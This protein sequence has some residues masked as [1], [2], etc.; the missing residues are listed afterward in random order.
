M[1]SFLYIFYD[2]PSPYESMNMYISFCGEPYCW[3]KV[4]ANPV[5]KWLA[6]PSPFFVQI[7]PSLAEY[8]ISAKTLV[9]AHREYLEF[10]KD[11]H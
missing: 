10:S 9:S 2:F 8:G 11:H 6:N 3:I 1:R 7:G 4:T 5:F